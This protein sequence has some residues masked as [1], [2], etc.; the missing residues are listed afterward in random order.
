[1]EV[2]QEHWYPHRMRDK[3]RKLHRHV[4]GMSRQHEEQR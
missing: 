4:M 1:M 2:N 3:R